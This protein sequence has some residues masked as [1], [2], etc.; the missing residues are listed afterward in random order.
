MIVAPFFGWAVANLRFCRD[1]AVRADLYIMEKSTLPNVHVGGG[2]ALAASLALLLSGA[3]LVA[4][5]RV[6]PV[7][8]QALTLQKWLKAEREQALAAVHATAVD[9]PTA[10]EVELAEGI[11]TTHWKNG[12]LVEDLNRVKAQYAEWR[13]HHRAEIVKLQASVDQAWDE[14]RRA[15][16]ARAALQRTLATVM[17]R[18]R[19]AAAPDPL[20]Q[21]SPDATTIDAAPQ[22]D[23]GRPGSSFGDLAVSP[24]EIA[25]W[26]IAAGLEQT[27]KEAML[28]NQEQ[29]FSVDLERRLVSTGSSGE[30]TALDP[31]IALSLYT[32]KTE[33]IDESSGGI[34]FFPDG[35]ATGGGIDLKLGRDRAAVR[36]HW[37]N[38]AVTVDAGRK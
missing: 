25:A 19:P 26:Q 9:L 2:Q 13:R 10:D 17:A 27:R 30:L 28:S 6:D 31:D 5:S 12:Q 38:G 21:Q 8:H 15:Q 3:I 35:R 32:A 11:Q 33:L 34:R 16:D 4:D 36:V 23:G 18:R 7:D 24:V 29:T 20:T 22:S 1:R 14:I 37:A